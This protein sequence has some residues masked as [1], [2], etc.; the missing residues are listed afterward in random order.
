[1]LQVLWKRAFYGHGNMSHMATPCER[2]MVDMSLI[3][4]AILSNAANS[5]RQGSPPS[6]WESDGLKND[7]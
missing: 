3:L 7:L 6:P 2:S 4:I 1:M 5:K